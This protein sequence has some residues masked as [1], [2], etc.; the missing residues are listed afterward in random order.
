MGELSQAIAD[1]VLRRVETDE[2]MVKLALEAGVDE[3]TIKWSSDFQPRR[4]NIK[5]LREFLADP[6]RAPMPSPTLE[7]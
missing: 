7:D 3:V 1:E 6:L 4:Y 5:R 2:A